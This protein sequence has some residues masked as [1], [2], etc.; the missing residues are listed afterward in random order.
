MG[1]ACGR[2]LGR[3]EGLYRV[4]VGRPEGKMPFGKTWRRQEDIIKKDLKEICWIGL[5]WNYLAQDSYKL[6]AGVN[7]VMNF[8]LLKIPGIY[9]QLSSSSLL[10]VVNQ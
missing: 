5:D 7:M 8:V 10:H 1:G 3:E 4:M 9:C 6:R 2:H